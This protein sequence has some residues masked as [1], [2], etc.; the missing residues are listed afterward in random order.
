MEF[1]WLFE[2]LAPKRAEIVCK[3]IFDELLS[4]V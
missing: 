4:T 3:I 1:C 2:G